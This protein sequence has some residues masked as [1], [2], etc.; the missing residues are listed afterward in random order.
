[1]KA[2]EKQLALNHYFLLIII[3][4]SQPLTWS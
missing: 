2:F 1:L 3:S 4:V